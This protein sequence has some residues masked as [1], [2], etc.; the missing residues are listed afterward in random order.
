M[1]HLKTHWIGTPDRESY[2]SDHDHMNS[3]SVDGS[4]IGIAGWLVPGSDYD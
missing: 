4:M 1:T 2:G 3:W